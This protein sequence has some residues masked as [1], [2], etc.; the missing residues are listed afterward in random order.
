[1]SEFKITYIAPPISEIPKTTYVKAQSKHIAVG[2]L[3]ANLPLVEEI[4]NI[5]EIKPTQ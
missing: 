5:E 3:Y 1:M 2:K 4:L